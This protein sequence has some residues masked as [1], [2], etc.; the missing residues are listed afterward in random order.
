M[1]QGIGEEPGLCRGGGRRVGGASPGGTS[2]GGTHTC[3]TVKLSVLIGLFLGGEGVNW[4][5]RASLQR[6]SSASLT[7]LHLN[8]QAAVQC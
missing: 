2:E 4:V 8:L 7:S 6:A 1:N 3:V 5:R